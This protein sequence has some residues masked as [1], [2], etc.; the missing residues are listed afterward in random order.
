M[1]GA[2]HMHY[3][4]PLHVRDV[5]IFRNMSCVPVIRTYLPH[6]PTAYQLA[7]NLC[8]WCEGALQ[9]PVQLLPDPM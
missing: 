1:R 6:A 5:I 7:W 3:G 4:V 9:Y 2:C 8:R